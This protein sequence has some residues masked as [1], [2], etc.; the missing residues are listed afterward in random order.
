MIYDAL[1]GGS[2]KSTVRLVSS[3]LRDTI[4]FILMFQYIHTKSIMIYKPN[5]WSLKGLN[6]QKAFS[7]YDI[8]ILQALYIELS[9]REN[10]LIAN[11]A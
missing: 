1:W 9:G 10:K 11:T 7:K 5:K 6:R 4:N 8:P 3:R 2:A